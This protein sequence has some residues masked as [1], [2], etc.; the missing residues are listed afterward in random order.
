M[1]LLSLLHHRLAFLTIALA[2]VSVSKANAQSWSFPAAPTDPSFSAPLDVGTQPSY[3][4]QQASAAARETGGAIPTF[5]GARSNGPSAAASGFQHG[6]SLGTPNVTKF[7]P[8]TERRVDINPFARPNHQQASQQQV[9]LTP[10]NQPDKARSGSPV[11]RLAR[12]DTSDVP[13]NG[14]SV[15]RAVSVELAPTR[16]VYTEAMVRSARESET[17]FLQVAESSTMIVSKIANDNASFAKK[18]ADLAENYIAL[19][20]R[21]DAAQS[22]LAATQQDFNDVSSKIEKYGLTPTIGML[23]R[24]KKEQLD[25][26]QASD[27]Q[28]SWVRESLQDSREAQLDL[29]LVRYDGTEPFDQAKQVLDGA[30]FDPTKPD[31]QALLRQVQQLLSDRGQWLTALWEGH[32]NY[33]EKLA[34]IDAITT[35]SASLTQD[36]RKLINRH[37]TWIRS[38]DAMGWDSV[39]KLSTGLVSLFNSN[40]GSE[41]GFSLQRKLRV[42]AASGV[43]VA[44]L[45]FAILALR[46]WAKSLLV[47]IGNRNRMRESTKS[48][49]KLAACGLTVLVAYSI[50]TILFSIATW[51]NSGFVSESL[52]QASSGFY[53]CSLIALMVELPRQLLRDFGLVD[54]HIGVD[55]PRRERACQYLM[56]VG[57]GLVLSAYAVTVSGLI[58][59]GMWRESVSRAGLIL[60]LFLVAWTFHRALQPTGGILEPLIEKF[61][62]A[63]VHRVRIVIYLFAIGSPLVIAFL[64]AVGYGFTAQ[65]LIYRFAITFSIALTCATL[66]PATKIVAAHCW[67]ILTGAESPQRKFDE[68]GEIEP[69]H[70]VDLSGGLYLD[71]KHQ[72]AFLCQCGLVVAGILFLG[73]LWIDVFPNLRMGNPVVWTVQETITTAAIGPSGETVMQAGVQEVPVTLVHVFFAGVTLFVAF[74]VA[75]LLPALFDALV[76]QR[77]SF[78]EGMEHFSLVLG[79]CLLFGAG[80]LI[81]MKWLGVRWQSVQWLAVGLTIGLGF[82]LQD[83]VRNVFGGLIVLFEKPAALGDLITVGRITGRVAKQHLRT[84]V[85]TDDEG[86]ENIIPNKKFVTDDVVNWMGAGRLTV[87]PIEVAV[88][89]DERPADICRTIQEFAVAQEDVLVLP[90]PQATLVCVSRTS[91]RIEVRVWIEDSSNPVGFRNSLLKRVRKYLAEINMLAVDQPEQPVIRDLAKD[92]DLAPR[93]T[94]RSA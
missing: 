86:R 76:L 65:E 54:K 69:T 13:A 9:D 40:R 42:N 66:W 49:R 39:R 94:R 82:G 89:K 27:S 59:Q 91:Q 88:T 81:S 33:Q 7:E 57:T 8:G 51:L 2:A 78:D 34:E 32:R 50:P 14:Q 36:Y 48:T 80:C 26:W 4:V 11:I 20:E 64:S 63:I 79:R 75:K 21:V 71:L 47:G 10:F 74:Q 84:T 62:G 22:K 35:A 25:R 15:T 19:A 5:P 29:E 18:W 77:V 68:Y 55:L 16:V 24:H 87:V 17:H 3:F 41:F 83:M 1:P 67:R 58:D 56:V 44:V 72:I 85:L 53:A 38:G 28:T 70:D 46:W 90:A 73:F 60:T 43:T 6:N 30:G 61:G 92:R 37:V 52:L 93:P 31:K 12:P 23:L 45:F